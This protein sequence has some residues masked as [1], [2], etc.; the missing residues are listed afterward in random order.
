[1]ATRQGF[2]TPY[3]MPYEQAMNAK[4]ADGRSDIYALGAT[5]YHLVAGEVPFPGV[6]HLEILDKKNLGFFAPASSLNPDVPAALDAILERMLARDPQ[7]RYQTASELIVDLERSE[8][9]ARVPS[10][11][12]AEL[13]LQDPLVRERLA[14]A[15]QPTAM[16]LRAHD[17]TAPAAAV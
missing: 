7:E 10:F 1:T 17:A 11:V 8:L 14:T 6:N 12:D 15:A 4:Y 3:Y 16:D 13:A 9:A 5:L 2:G